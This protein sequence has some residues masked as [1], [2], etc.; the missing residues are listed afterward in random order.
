MYRLSTIKINFKMK[1]EEKITKA[2]NEPNSRQFLDDHLST[3]RENI[4]ECSKKINQSFFIILILIALTEAINLKIV[5]KLDFFSAEINKLEFILIVMPCLIAHYTYVLF[6]QIIMRWELL[7]LYNRIIKSKHHNICELDLDDFLI[8]SMTID[9]EILLCRGKK[10]WDKILLEIFSAPFVIVFQ[11]LP[12]IYCVYIIKSIWESTLDNYF[13]I[14]IS[15]VV[16]F[17]YFLR[18]TLLFILAIRD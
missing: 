1:L 3:F 16:T 8:T 18:A 17:L 11:Y 10:R 2:L 6:N 14:W 5:E 4:L 9:T 15:V 7:T 13:F 12:L